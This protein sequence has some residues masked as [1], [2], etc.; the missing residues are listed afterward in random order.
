[1]IKFILT[2]NDKL[3]IKKLYG[4][5]NEESENA[6]QSGRKKISLGQF[7]N[8]GKYL[9]KDLTQFN[10]AIQEIDAFLKKFPKNQ[11]IKI[12]VQAGESQ[13]P[14]RDGEVQGAPQLAQ[15]ALAQKRMDSVYKI[16]KEKFGNLPNVSIEVS[17]PTIG[18]TPYDRNK[19]LKDPNYKDSQEFKNEQFVNVV[20]VAIGANTTQQTE[21]KCG[22]YTFYFGNIT[23]R[24][25][26]K[27][28][29]KKFLNMLHDGNEN[30]NLMPNCNNYI[31]EIYQMKK[32]EPTIVNNTYTHFKNVGGHFNT[33]NKL[34]YPSEKIAKETPNAPGL[35]LINPTDYGMTIV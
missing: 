10:G 8:S 21:N 2:E 15:G 9:I 16:I 12:Q 20:L 26:N 1:M 33:V 27:E 17:K 6:T 30:G 7:F 13:V 24:T 28:D 25:S 4:L 32:K 3:E 31:G 5:I 11:K 18:Q 23:F 14:N 34:I 22:A 19:A 29:A 35:K